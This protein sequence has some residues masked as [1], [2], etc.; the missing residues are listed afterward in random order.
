[1]YT[2]NVAFRL[3]TT[4]RS[5]ASESVELV[6]S[7][8]RARFRLGGGETSVIGSPDLPSRGTTVE[9]SLEPLESP[10]DRPTYDPVRAHKVASEIKILLVCLTSGNA[11]DIR[12]S[13][14]SN[15]VELDTF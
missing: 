10:Y 6:R 12:T 14:L 7:N 11:F 5:E 2:V 13:F 9:L 8:I 15:G 1:M 3:K 4:N